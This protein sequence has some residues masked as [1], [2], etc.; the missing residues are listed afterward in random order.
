VAC[1]GAGII[2]G[3]IGVT[4]LGTKI[5]SGLI[6]F[7]NGNLLLGLI[8]TMVAAII[9]GTGMPVTAVY[10]ILAATLV[11]P[12]VSMGAQPIAAHMFIFMFAAVAG[13]TP[14]VAITS[15]T[16]AGIAQ[17]DPNAV[18][19]KGFL[20][21]LPGYIIPFIFVFAPE[22]LMVGKPLEVM[23]AIVTAFFGICCLVA[24]I[25]GHF[26]G[27]WHP[28]LRVILFGAALLLLKPGFGTDAIAIG[29]IAMSF[30]LRVVFQT[31]RENKP[32]SNV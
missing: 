18:A 21:G 25:E 5:A 12:L 16:A 19:V 23:L 30:L 27:Y 14:P 8:L 10:I 15:Y 26:F 32:T 22:L 28:L 2:V 31:R 1:A 13:L 11:Q 7:S 20:Y 6:S 29:V 24:V 3:V 17:T 4:G 9:L